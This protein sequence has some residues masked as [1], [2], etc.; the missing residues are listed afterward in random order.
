VVPLTADEERDILLKRAPGGLESL[1]DRDRD[2]VKN[3]HD[4]QLERAMDLLKGIA[5]FTERA[6]ADDKNEKMAAVK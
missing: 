3:S 4:P 6:P 2:R 1:E 5:L